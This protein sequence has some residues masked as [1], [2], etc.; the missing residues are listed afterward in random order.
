MPALDV[1]NPEKDPFE[2]EEDEG[3]DEFQKTSEQLE[4]DFRKGAFQAAL[5]RILPLRPNEIRTLLERLD[6]TVEST[7]T[8]VHPYPRPE[9][10]VQ[11]ISLDPGS[12]LL[13]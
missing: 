11:N 2:F 6:R 1:E 5:N 3:L 7:E 13:P 8:P 10:V 9:S 4:D 12:P